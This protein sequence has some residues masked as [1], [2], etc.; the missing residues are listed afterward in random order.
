MT[1]ELTYFKPPRNTEAKLHCLKLWS[2]VLGQHTANTYRVL[3]TGIKWLGWLY[4]IY[5]Y[6]F[7]F[8]FSLWKEGL[9]LTS[10]WLLLYFLS[11]EN[12]FPKD[13]KSEL[14]SNSNLMLPAFCNTKPKAHVTWKATGVWT[15]E[16]QG[17][18][19]QVDRSSWPCSFSISPKITTC[20]FQ[21]GS[22]CH[23]ELYSW[24]LVIPTNL[25][26]FIPANCI[27][28]LFRCVGSMSRT[29]EEKLA[30]G[31]PN[32][33]DFATHPERKGG[34][35]DDKTG[36][37]AL[38]STCRYLQ[39]ARS[40]LRDSVWGVK[41]V[42]AAGVGWGLQPPVWCSGNSFCWKGQCWLRGQCPFPSQDV[43]LPDLTS[44][45]LR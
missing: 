15:V 16:R 12:I 11:T 32:W 41:G 44:C 5:I 37:G 2:I 43:Y 39:A 8:S 28:D 3:G 26:S 29:P 25:E 31:D 4:Y 36:K 1:T 33:L 45:N 14:G 21:E 6:I 20:D 13:F 35:K 9:I 34:R 10:L 27:I 7:G 30:S 19:W 18:G 40:E 17:C 23:S 42:A 22:D 38:P 24:Q